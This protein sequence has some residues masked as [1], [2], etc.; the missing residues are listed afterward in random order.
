V[1]TAGC[2]PSK[3]YGRIPC[4]SCL[5]KI[6]RVWFQSHLTQSRA[7]FC[8]HLASVTVKAFSD[9]RHHWTNFNLSS[10]ESS[11][12]LSKLFRFL[13]Q[14]VFSLFLLK[15]GLILTQKKFEYI[16]WSNFWMYFIKLY[17]ASK[18]QSKGYN[19]IIQVVLKFGEDFWNINNSECI[20]DL[21][22]HI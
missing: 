22:I 12:L 16:L 10:P 20:T 7:Q 3:K 14:N 19:I 2:L 18:E 21:G 8:H 9:L 5:F 6:I 1:F 4:S 11:C 15:F 13:L 17:I